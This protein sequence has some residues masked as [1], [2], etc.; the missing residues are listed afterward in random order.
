M[1]V[2]FF[3][4]QTRESMVVSFT[5]LIWQVLSTNWLKVNIDGATGGCC[6]LSTCTNIFRESRGEYVD[7]FSALLGV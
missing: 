2:K 5:Y 1:W 4:I 3:N 6:G 7:S